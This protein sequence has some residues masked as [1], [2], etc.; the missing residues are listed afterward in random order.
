VSLTGPTEVDVFFEEDEGDADDDGGNGL[1]E[2]ETEIVSMTLTG[3]SQIA[4]PITVRESS[5]RR[6]V[7]NTPGLLDVNPFAPG[8]ADSFFDVFFEIEVG[9]QT[10][11]NEDP[12]RME[13]VIES[14]P[15]GRGTTYQSSHEPIELFDEAGNPTGITIVA[16]EH[17]P[18][19][20]G[21]E[22][23][24]EV[25]GEV[26]PVDKLTILASWILLAVTLIVVT[27]VVLRR[28]RATG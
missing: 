26:Y 13:A 27:A 21:E 10:L 5:L 28:R 7:N 20:N 4:G 2:V 25:G 23:P 15:P 24:V 17:T 3:V 16:E 11:H 18:V 8:T 14:K 1:E 12:V 6:T 9:G 22:P 19:P